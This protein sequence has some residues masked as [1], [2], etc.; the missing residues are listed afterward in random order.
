MNRKMKLTIGIAGLLLCALPAMAGNGNG[1]QSD[2]AYGVNSGSGNGAQDGT[3]LW[4]PCVDL[5]YDGMVAITDVQQVINM[6]LGRQLGA[7]EQVNQPVRHFFVASPR[8]A[9][10]LAP[11]AADGSTCCPLI[12]A[13][14]NFAREDSQI[15]VR[16]GKRVAFRLD[17]NLEGV[18]YPGACGLLGTR[19]VVDMRPLAAEDGE[20]VEL[21]RSG[22]A[23]VRCGPS[24]GRAN[25]FVPY[26]F[27]DVGEYLVRARILS[28]A[29]PVP[30]PAEPPAAF[31]EIDPEDPAAPCGRAVAF[32][33]V[34]VVVRV[35]ETDP[36][37][38]D[39]EWQ[40]VPED[41]MGAAGEP[42]QPGPGGSE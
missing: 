24:V 34:F 8:L 41:P 25:I 42:L 38:A 23:A 9:L 11:E 36:T 21:G 29:E 22:A 5:D 31:D 6:A 35:I 15:L 20:W 18:W 13:A 39:L 37:E 32:N 16:A 28:I 12:G 17:R 40:N 27:A 14:F 3:G 19:L 2:N 4:G 30:D 33:E 1:N 7:T 10:S 26:Q